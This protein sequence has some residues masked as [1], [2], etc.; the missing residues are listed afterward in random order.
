MSDSLSNA[1]KRYSKKTKQKNI[2]FYIHEK[3]LYDFACEINFQKFCK[4]ALRDE[5]KRRKQND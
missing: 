4:D 2:T 5:Y 3:E 1:R